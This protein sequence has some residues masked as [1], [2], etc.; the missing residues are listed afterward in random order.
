MM[1]HPNRTPAP[2]TPILGDDC[3]HTTDPDQCRKLAAKIFNTTLEVVLAVAGVTMLTVQTGILPVG[4]KKDQGNWVEILSQVMN[5]VFMWKTVTNHPYYI[6]RLVMASHVLN[7]SDEQRGRKWGPGIRGACYLQHQFPLLVFHRATIL[8]T[9][10]DKSETQCF[11]KS[12]IA[13]DSLQT[14]I[15]EIS[16]LGNYLFLRDDVKHLQKSLIILNCGCLFQYLMT[17]Y[18]WSYDASS[19]PAFVM[20]ALLPPTILCN[21]IGEYRLKKLNKRGE[22]RRLIIAD[23]IPVFRELSI[24]RAVTSP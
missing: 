23:G 3:N 15:K 12:D 18:M 20:P 14:T 16:R 4:D 10:V 13:N 5:C 22:A 17:A 7:S 2:A 1:Y 21:V 24:Q 19:R 9:D 6:V 11:D 8:D